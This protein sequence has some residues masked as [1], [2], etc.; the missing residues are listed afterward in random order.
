M[1]I[2]IALGAGARDLVALVVGE[3]LAVVAAGIAIGWAAAAVAA[4]LVSG[5]LYVDAADPTTF[6]AVALGLGVVMFVATYLPARRVSAGHP[7]DAL[8]SE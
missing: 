3:G 7:L 2:R 6:A 5:F 8:R 1:G 4:R